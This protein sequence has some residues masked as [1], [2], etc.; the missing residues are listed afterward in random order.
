MDLVAYRVMRLR[1]WVSSGEYLTTCVWN[2]IHHNNNG[3]RGSLEELNK[4][5]Y[6][7][8]FCWRI[9]P[10][11]ARDVKSSFDD[12]GRATRSLNVS[13]WAYAIM[14]RN[15]A[16][17]RRLTGGNRQANIRTLPPEIFLNESLV[18]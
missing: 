18:A 6:G 7:L 3:I 2:F 14:P 5:E 1:V 9:S 16:M 12:Q 4:M 13:I 8:G 10:H 11:E 17:L 15:F